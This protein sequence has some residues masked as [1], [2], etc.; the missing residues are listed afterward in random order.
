[1]NIKKVNNLNC[2]KR[3]VQQYVKIF[4]EEGRRAVNIK[5]NLLEKQMYQQL[6]KLQNFPS[7]SS[8]ATQL[9]VQ[10]AA[11]LLRKYSIVKRPANTSFVNTGASFQSLNK[12]KVC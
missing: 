3:Y 11:N 4:T 6:F 10:Q 9:V 2:L 7:S 5:H 8:D 12:N 1:M